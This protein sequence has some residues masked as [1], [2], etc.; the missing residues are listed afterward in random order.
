[1]TRYDLTLF[2]TESSQAW[3]GW[4]EYN[5]DIFRPESAGRLVRHYR[6][7]VEKVLESPDLRLS[8]IPMMDDEEMASV[9]G[10][11]NRTK[12]ESAPP[13]CVHRLF[14]EQAAASPSGAAVV[15]GDRTLSYAEINAR[16][17]A[18]ARG[19][20]AR[21]AGPEEIIGV[22]L[23]RT[24]E[25]I[26]AVLGVLKSGAAY[27][28]LDTSFPKKRIFG[29]LEDAGAMAVLG[30]KE[31]RPPSRG[32]EGPGPARRRSRPAGKRLRG[33]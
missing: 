2:L 15:F 20:A 23:D 25:M 4:L 10:G 18:I 27:L 32:L 13:A 14:E 19:L 5:S 3:T 1:M 30:G 31:A 12:T 29:F 7:L 16:A 21:G 11:W 22:C 28:P 24:P 8:E 17:D 33:R 9:T 26:A 6:N